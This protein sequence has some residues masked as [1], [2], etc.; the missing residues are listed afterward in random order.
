MFKTVLS[1]GA[2]SMYYGSIG[3]EISPETLAAFGKIE[4][5]FIGILAGIIGASCYNYFKN[6]KL[7]VFLSFFSGKRAVAIVTGVVTLL[8]CV[9]LVFLWPVLFSGLQAFGKTITSAGALGAGIYGFLNRLL[10]PVGLHH[11]LN[12]V[13]WFDAAGIGDLFRFWGGKE[14]FDVITEQV[15]LF[16]G[17]NQTGMYMTG[18]FPVMMFG[19][20]GAALAMYLQA[21]SNKKKVVAA[22]FLQL[23]YHLSL[24]V[25]LN[26]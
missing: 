12:S 3:R 25:L 21:K 5:Q 20:P 2:V 16:A 26:H 7:P 22:Y 9:P 11:A 13:F 19:L 23:L 14:G 18:F 4:N 10:I 17:S 6:T 15:G 24:P 1:Q 8:V